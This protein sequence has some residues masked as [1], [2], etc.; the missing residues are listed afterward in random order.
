MPIP[1][2]MVNAM[3]IPSPT[4]SQ[5]RYEIGRGNLALAKRMTHEIARVNA[6]DPEAWFLRGL[7]E[8]LGGE[9]AAA[10]ESYQKSLTLAP[11][12]VDPLNNLGIIYLAMG[13]IA[14]AAELSERYVRQQPNSAIANCNYA[15]VLVHLGRG[16]DAAA[17]YRYALSLRPEYGDALTNY[18][19]YLLRSGQPQE[20]VLMFRRAVMLQPNS[21]VAH[22][23][24]GQALSCANEN[25]AAE[26]HLREALRINPQSS[27]TLSDLGS[28]FAKTGKN[29]AAIDHFRR[30]L[31]IQPKNVLALSNLG[32]A[33]HAQGKS[34]EA[35]DCYNRALSLQPK[36]MAAHCNMGKT[37]LELCRF[38]EAESA[39]REAIAIDPKCAE[40]HNLLGIVYF[41]AGQDD[42]A[43]KTFAEAL[44]LDPNLIRAK[45]NRAFLFL[46]QGDFARGWPDYELRFEACDVLRSHASVPVWNGSDLKGRTILIT[47]EQGIGDVL[48][49]LRFLPLVQAKGGRVVCELPAKL[50]PLARLCRGI[51][52][53]I[54]AGD[55]LPAVDVQVSIM[56]LA[57]LLGTI[58]APEPHLSADPGLVRQW[59]E[60]LKSIAGLR[61]GVAWQGAPSFRF[62]LIRSTPLEF[63][64]A[65]AKVPGVSLINL[66]KHAG[67]D[68]IAPNKERVPLI[69]LGPD[70]DEAAGAFMDTAAI[71]MNLD[72]VITSDSAV[73]HLAGG[74]GVP[75][76]TAIHFAPDWRWFL[77][78][79]DSPWYS[80]MRLFRQASF[81][82]W[83]GVFERLAAAVRDEVARRSDASVVYGSGDDSRVCTPQ[84]SATSVCMVPMS[85]GELLD[86]ITILRLK[87]ERMTNP[88]QLDN[89]RTELRALEICRDQL[90]LQ[91]VPIDDLVDQ[92]QTVNGAL[93]QVEDEL[94]NC[95]RAQDFGQRFIE[96]ARSVYQH[97]DRRASLKRKINASLGSSLTEEKTHVLAES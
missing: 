48:Q 38:D 9:I 95:E 89:V 75:V 65:I 91:R 73:A 44:R 55:P 6:N 14:E 86:K 62:D 13:R 4:V 79:D 96:L 1:Q 30:A 66:Q 39:L 21:D 29:E 87:A 90:A 25:E 2:P 45:I 80:T 26:Y 54:A 64:E 93:W 28:T 60:S 82:D 20:A 88:S 81:G 34:D 56:S 57:A 76:W 70:M 59:G 50:L 53:L 43:E 11:Q 7:A 71:M 67:L 83:A 46:R 3:M 32:I 31:A 23:N 63:F 97:N 77:G 27:E 40:A 5:A 24:V 33:L 92:L 37:L 68:Q 16:E 74:L 78:R 41:H 84:S 10:M 36:M 12:Y 51:D 18:G 22:R 61:I 58:D 49:F 15:N 72:L 69:D 17:H 8:H 35:L 47:A 19:A 52:Q 85:P 42:K 94:R